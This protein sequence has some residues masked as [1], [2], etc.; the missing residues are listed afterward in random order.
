MSLK[1]FFFLAIF[2][3]VLSPVILRL[4]R[5]GRMEYIRNTKLSSELPSQNPLK[6]KAK[7]K[8]SSWLLKASD[9]E[10]FP[11]EIES[12]GTIVFPMTKPTECQFR[13]I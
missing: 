9:A 5:P 1:Q 12:G 7:E 6:S 4:V 2:Q 8:N 13:N 3:L 11:N 10:D